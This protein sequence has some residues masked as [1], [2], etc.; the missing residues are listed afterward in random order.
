MSGR[1]SYASMPM[2]EIPERRL[3]LS[4]FRKDEKKE[5]GKNAK[6][7]KSGRRS[8]EGYSMILCSSVASC[9]NYCNDKFAIS[10]MHCYLLSLASWTIGVGKNESC[11]VRKKLQKLNKRKSTSREGRRPIETMRH[12]L[13]SPQRRILRL[14]GKS[15]RRIRR[16]LDVIE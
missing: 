11:H 5:A 15:E 6:R 3:A 4:S 2:T 10:L 1:P 7:I 14:P 8:T 12:R 13:R 9:D 16:K